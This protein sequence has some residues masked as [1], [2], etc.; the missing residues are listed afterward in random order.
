MSKEVI[1]KNTIFLYVRMILIMLVTLF[2][3]RVVLQVLGVNDY[4]IYQTVGGVVFLLSFLNSALSAGSSRFLTYE[5]GTGNVEKLKITFSSIFIVHT[6]LAFIIVLIAESIGVW[7][8]K[9]KLNIPLDRLDAGVFTFH[10]S[11]FAVF[12]SVTQVPYNASIISHEKMSI[13]AYLSILEVVL[14]L[15][16]VYLLMITSWDKLKIYAVLYCAVQVGVACTYRIYCRKSF[17]ECRTSL[18][19]DRSIVKN[20][21]NYSSWNLLTN[22]AAAGVIHGTTLLINIFF[23]PGIV[24]ARAIANQVNT[25]AIQLVQNF[26][27]AVNPQIVKRLA[28]GDFEGSKRLLL[29]STK[30]SFF[31]MLFLCVPIVFETET[32][33]QLWLGVVP[34]Q[35]AIFLKLVVVT[36]LFQTF[37]QSFY[38]ALYAKGVIRGNAIYTSLIG[39][40]ALIVVFVLFK[41]GFPP[42][43]L[44]WVVLIEEVFLA[45]VVKPILV[46]KV[47]G[48]QWNDMRKTFLSCFKVALISLPAPF[49]V[50]W[51][52]TVYVANGCVQFI[53]VVAASVVSVGVA[54]WT[55]GFDS[56]M[57]S[58]IVQIIR[59]KL[60]K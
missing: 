36:T 19:F 13:Y 29:I 20:V 44:A 51:L 39:F 46:I 26:R 6:V 58:F 4:G 50:Y 18:I 14:K 38:T 17:S 5:L 57:K 23:N 10:F 41:C 15:V 54:V 42:I 30:I 40:L 16:I 53:S 7:F 56:E 24:T 49:V 45:L 34:D 33:L 27:N 43:A 2:T 25:A 21:L 52:C 3:S 47:A 55:I 1:A 11:V 22:A 35:C 59:K 48:Y 60:K 12:F 28:Q 8:V 37:S 31:L 9:N 32:L